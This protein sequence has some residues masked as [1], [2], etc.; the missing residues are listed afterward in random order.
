[1]RFLGKVARIAGVGVALVAL[2]AWWTQPKR[3][4]DSFLVRPAGAGTFT[5]G[6][7]PRGR[8]LSPDEIDGYARRLLAEMSLEEKVLQMSGDSWAWDLLTERWIGRGWSAG[9]DRRLGL[10][11]LVCTDGPRGVGMGSSTCFPTPM[12]RAASWDRALEA[13]V[14]DAAAQE[15]RGHGAN[16]WLAPCLNVLRH[17]RWG[18]AQESYGEDPYL[19]GEMGA[20]LVDGAQRHNVMAC[21]KHYALNSI[22]ETR[23][24]VDVRVD[25]RTLREVYLPQFARVVQAGV[26]SVMSAY[27][28][29][30]GDYCAENRRLLREILKDEWGFRGFVMSDF[31]TGVHDGVKAVNAGLDLEMPTTWVLGGKLRAAV[32]AGRVPEPAVDQ[33]VV[34]LLRRRID[35][36]TRPE[37]MGYGP[38]VVRAPAHVALAREAAEKSLVLLQNDG[39]LP[40]DRGRIGTLAVVGALADAENIGDHGSSRV[41]PPHV[42][43]ILE[44]L[45]AALGPRARVVHEP[46][47]DLARAR[48]AARGAD[49]VV[50]VAG[51][52]YADEGEYIPL[53]VK[54]RSEWGGDRQSL[55]LRPADQ[56]LIRAV[57]VENPRTVVVLVGG[58]AI[59]VEEWKDRVGAI[60]MAFYP[61]EE[62]GHAVARILMGDVNPSGKLPFTVPKDA[63]QLPAFDNR[64]LT[65]E[66]GYYHGYTLADRKGFVPAFPF[67]HGLS[68]TTFRYANL[69]VEE[70]EI[71][72]DGEIRASVDV[73]NTG[74][75]AG[76]E[77]AQLYVGFAGSKVDRPVKLLRGFE[78]VALAPGET[79]RVGF[80]VK[81]KDLAYYDPEA[82]RWVVEKTDYQVLVGP[83]SRANDLLAARVRV[84]DLRPALTVTPP[85]R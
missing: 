85:R 78:K 68:Y 69:A 51:F 66:Y 80:V 52:T 18:R 71:G 56:V 65:V 76:E 12:A 11:P 58:A 36:A 22:E 3:P 13:R 43:T 40:L 20:A 48:A 82:R 79:K 83:S 21:A 32:E 61:G 70:T 44:G 2:G 27:N 53:S 73:T 33:A 49:A 54:A 37:R 50:V 29:V 9:A 4:V 45:R 38:A 57:A 72:D 47:A 60:L 77:A 35:Y 34:R 1:M 25:E 59:T 30:D 55:A 15:V 81:A 10:P 41:R 67:G 19:V 23:M 17:P 26:A 75:R 64:S 39:L 28:R 42:V 63:S 46:G 14:A 74:P 8:A 84:G 7:I 31:F 24:R 6:D 62:G 16:L 5:F